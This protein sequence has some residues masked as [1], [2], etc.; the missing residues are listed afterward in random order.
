MLVPEMIYRHADGEVDFRG[1]I[2]SV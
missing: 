1:R 2:H